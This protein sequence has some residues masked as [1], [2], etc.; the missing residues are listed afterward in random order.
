M[1]GKCQCIHIPYGL[2][3]EVWKFDSKLSYDNRA[4][5]SWGLLIFMEWFPMKIREKGKWKEKHIDYLYLREQGRRLLV[6]LKLGLY[7][8]VFILTLR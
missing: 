6:Y 5:A 1:V 4:M 2:L 7:K 3:I 8:R